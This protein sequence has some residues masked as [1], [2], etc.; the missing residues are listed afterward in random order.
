[1]LRDVLNRIS[2]LKKEVKELAQKDKELA[3]KDKEQAQE[4]KIL[5]Q[6]QL[7]TQVQRGVS[8]NTFEYDMFSKVHILYSHSYYHLERS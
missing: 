1:M 6:W 5:W 7:R 4:D 2:D 3:Q 8:N